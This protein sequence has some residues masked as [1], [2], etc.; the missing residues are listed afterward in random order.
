MTSLFEFDK[1][2]TTSG[3]AIREFNDRYV[4]AQG[5]AP[6]SS[7]TT[8]FGDVMPTNSPMVTFPISQLTGEYVETKG[9]STFQSAQETDLD[10]KVVEYDMG[11]AAKLI[12]ILT[13][14]FAYRKWNQASQRFVTGEQRHIAK[15]IATLL[16]AGASTACWDGVNFFATN[17]PANKFKNIDTWSNYASGGLDV[18]SIGNIIAQCTAMEGEVLDEVGEKLGVSPTHILLPT[19]KYRVVDALLK[20]QQ[21]AAASGTGVPSSGTGTMSNPLTGLTAVHVPQLTDA[22]DWY[23]VDANLVRALPPWLALRYSAPPALALRT[24]DESSDF[25]KN[26]GKLKMSSHIWY[27]FSLVFPHAI[28]KIVGA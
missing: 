27:G 4:A 18:N 28:R 24:W 10:V 9:D 15:N 3:E 16:E 21:V 1:L 13:K 5:V 19:E 17:H 22:N 11:Y 23:L 20:Q 6:P 14:V 25:F 2:P 8:D 7:W 12:D 26:T